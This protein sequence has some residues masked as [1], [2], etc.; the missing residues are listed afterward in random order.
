[1]TVLN[2]LKT[3]PELLDLAFLS[4]HD[5]KELLL[6]IFVRDIEENQELK[7]RDKRIYPIK[8]DGPIEMG[9]EF[10]HL[11]CKEMDEDG[12]GVNRRVFDMNRSRRLHWIKPHIMETIQEN[13]IE[14]FSVVER[15]REKRK[16]VF[17]T[18]IYNTVQKYVIVMEPQVRNGKAYYLLTAYYLDEDYGEKMMKKKMKKRC[19]EV[20]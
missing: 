15:D 12:S 5:R 14:V 6:K 3:Y 9:R 13:G 19:Q 18:Y 17:R 1:M 20:L 8:D 11:T 4:E 10:T 7:F 16:D 2:L